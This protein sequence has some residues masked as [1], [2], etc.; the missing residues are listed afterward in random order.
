MNDSGLPISIRPVGIARATDDADVMVI[1]VKPEFGE[2][3]LLIEEQKHLLVLYWMH[4]LAKNG[5]APLQ[6]HPRGD[7]SIPLHGVF[8]THSPR[9][10]NPIGVTR[11]EVVNIEGNRLFVR[12]LDA[13]DGSPIIDIKSG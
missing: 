9:R 12:G 5:G 7:A 1:E 13:F 4:R 6:V 11:V 10:P 8:A 3:L 2:A